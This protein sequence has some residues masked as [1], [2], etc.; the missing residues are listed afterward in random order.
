MTKNDKKWRNDKNE[1]K[2]QEIKV[3]GK[4]HGAVEK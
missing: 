2:W 1:K 4:V 3:K